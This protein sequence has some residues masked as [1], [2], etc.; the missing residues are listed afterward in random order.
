LA[1]QEGVVAV[2]HAGWRGLEVGVVGRAVATMRAVGASDVTAAL[3][4]CI[5]PECY[6]FSPADLDRLADRLGA[7]V[8][9][10]TSDGRPALDV[11]AAVASA[12]GDAGVTLVHDEAVCT[13][14]SSEH[15]SHRARG[16]LERQGTLVWLP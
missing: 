1:S 5:R 9:G 2:V 15:F 14:C 3:G 12:L 13:S 7:A 4:P 16:E 6:E 10:E 11:P 8:R